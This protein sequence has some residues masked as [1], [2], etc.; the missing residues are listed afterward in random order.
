MLCPPTRRQPQLADASLS[1]SFTPKP[2]NTPTPSSPAASAAHAQACTYS[3]VPFERQNFG[4]FFAKPPGDAVRVTTR[5]RGAKVTTTTATTYCFSLTNNAMRGSPAKACNEADVCCE[6][7]TSKLASFEIAARP[8]CIANSKTKALLTGAK[9]TMDGRRM[10]RTIANG[11]IRVSMP[12]AWS[13][14]SGLV[15]VEISGAC[16]NLG[17]LCTAMLSG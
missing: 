8:E 4:A 11:N 12:S 1:P 14:D 13:A 16:C 6:P 10:R 5:T 9:W 7:L 17:G 3:G 2:P 15:C